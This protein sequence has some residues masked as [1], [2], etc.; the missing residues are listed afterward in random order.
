MKKILL[1]A[2]AVAALCVAT[3]EASA[4]GGRVVVQQRGFLRPRVV[5]QQ[6][7]FAPPVVLRQRGFVAPFGFSTPHCVGPQAFFFGF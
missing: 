1:A 2:A 7:H 3:G 5:V 4:T 6:R